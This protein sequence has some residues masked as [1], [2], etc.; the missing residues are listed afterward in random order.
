[1]E[2]MINR[3]I[4]EYAVKDVGPFTL[5]QAGCLA[6]A[7]VCGYGVFFLEKH[8]LGL[9]SVNEFQIISILIAALPGIA[10]GFIR[11]YKLS[12]WQYLRTIMFENILSP[13]IRKYESDFD[14]ES[15]IKEHPIEELNMNINQKYTKEEK[16]EI[17]KWKSYR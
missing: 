13:K 1:M 3:D 9:T 6:I 17:K 8:F 16:K 4:R 14:Y 5:K 2:V 7:A 10:F 15:F 11:P 12:L